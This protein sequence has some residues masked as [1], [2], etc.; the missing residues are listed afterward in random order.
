M[1]GERLVGLWIVVFGVV[2][3]YVLGKVKLGEDDDERKVSV[4]GLLMGLG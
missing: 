1:E 2:G 3:L 4:G